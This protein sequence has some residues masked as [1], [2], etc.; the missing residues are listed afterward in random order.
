MAECSAHPRGL[1]H[2]DLYWHL[3]DPER[4]PHV[5]AGPITGAGP[6]RVGNA[7]VQVLGCQGIDHVLASTY[8]DWRHNLE[9]NPDGYPPRP[10]ILAIARR[11]G[12]SI[13]PAS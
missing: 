12:T 10:P 9:R 3:D 2:F 11:Y 1:L 8:E 5:V 13:N 7:V 6:W 4:T